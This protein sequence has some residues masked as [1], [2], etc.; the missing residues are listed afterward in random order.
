SLDSVEG[1][2][3]LS[4]HFFAA[5]SS[6]NAGAVIAAEAAIS[7][8]A[9]VIIRMRVPLK[10]RLLLSKCRMLVSSVAATKH[11]QARV[12][13]GSARFRLAQTLRK[14]TTAETSEITVASHR[15]EISKPSSPIG[16]VA[17]VSVPTRPIHNR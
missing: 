9:L 15:H 5:A 10:G 13:P 1:G 7:A 16:S 2:N 11:T 4:I 17:I 6:A 8:T 3:S 12:D 14:M